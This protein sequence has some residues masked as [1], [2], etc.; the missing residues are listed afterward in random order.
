VR[1]LLAAGVPVVTVEDHG[2]T[3]GFGAAV[4]ESAQEQGLDASRVLRLG[5]PDGWIYQDSRAKQLAEAGI[6]AAGIARALRR[7]VDAFA[8]GAQIEPRPAHAAQ[9]RYPDPAGA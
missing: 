6:D 8:P 9:A 7:A 1:A 2:L 3:G 5:L 4:L